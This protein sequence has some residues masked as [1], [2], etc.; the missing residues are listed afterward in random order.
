LIKAIELVLEARKRLQVHV[1][2]NLNVEQLCI[3]LR[4]VLQRV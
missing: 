1:A 2:P 3:R 4:E